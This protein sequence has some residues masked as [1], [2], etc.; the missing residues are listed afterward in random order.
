MTLGY[1]AGDKVYIFTRRGF[2]TGV[3]EKLT[4][5]GQIVVAVGASRDRFTARGH[6]V[7]K[8]GWGAAYLVRKSEQDSM[9]A[10]MRDEIVNAKRAGEYI[11]EIEGIR[12]IEVR[13]E[14]EIPKAIAA[15][16]ALAEKLEA[17]APTTDKR[18]V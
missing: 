4:A 17:T 2:R 13:F 15:L 16:R 12:K 8:V 14:A 1:E 9:A 7:G 11:Q 3:V 10:S 5:S 6:E 18:E